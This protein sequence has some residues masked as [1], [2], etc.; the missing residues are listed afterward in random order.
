MGDYFDRY[1]RDEAHLWDGNALHGREPRKGGFGAPC[2]GVAV[3]GRLFAGI[4]M[5]A[6]RPRSRVDPFRAQRAVK[7]FQIAWWPFVDNSY[8]NASGRM[9]KPAVL[10]LILL[11]AAM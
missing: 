2:R 10:P 11:V 1:V 3:D 6:G 9:V 7:Q 8:R 5:R 4:R